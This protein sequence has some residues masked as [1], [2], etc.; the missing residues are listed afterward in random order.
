M[1]SFQDFAGQIRLGYPSLVVPKKVPPA[2]FGKVVKLLKEAGI[3]VEDAYIIGQW[4]GRQSWIS[5]PLTVMVV[6]QKAGEWLA[7]ATAEK[8]K[9]GPPTKKI[10]FVEE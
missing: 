9:T 7:K 4:L 10:K 2:Y 8:P 6:A 5:S 3:T 1:L